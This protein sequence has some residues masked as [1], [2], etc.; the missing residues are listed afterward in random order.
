[1]ITNSKRSTKFLAIAPLLLLILSKIICKQDDALAQP[2]LW[3]AYIAEAVFI[4]HLIIENRTVHWFY[5]IILG[6]IIIGSVGSLFKIMHWHL[7][8]VLIM[9]GI[10]AS[11]LS[12]VAMFYS[13]MNQKGRNRSYEFLVLAV[14]ILLQLILAIGIVV[15]YDLPVFTYAKFLHYPIAAMCGVIL[16]KILYKNIGE[17]NLVLY[18]LVHSLFVIIKQTFQFFG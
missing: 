8:S 14:C 4:L 5:S 3:A 9:A 12:V 6:L 15:F 2:F 11:V 18:L 17:R 10:V 7:A 1:M 13:A 16:L